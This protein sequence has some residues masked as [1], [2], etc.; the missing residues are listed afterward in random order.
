METTTL[1]LVLFLHTENPSKIT[2]HLS[3]KFDPPKNGYFKDRNQPTIFLWWLRYIGS[4]RMAYS[5]TM[6]A[7]VKGISLYIYIPL[8]SKDEL[9][10]RFQIQSM[11]C[12][13][14]PHSGYLIWTYMGVS[15]NSAT[16]TWMVKIMGTPIHPWMI[17]RKTPLFSEFFHPY[18]KTKSTDPQSLTPTVL[19]FSR[20]WTP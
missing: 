18:E 13:M 7:L 1:V 16:P 4:W 14:L 6:W 11:K 20:R 12:R 17:W 19:R 5:L 10:G 3:I 9:N 15:K 8:P 2:I